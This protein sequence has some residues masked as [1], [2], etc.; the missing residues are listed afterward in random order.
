MNNATYLRK[1]KKALSA[2]EKS[3]IDNICNEI[4]S[5][6]VD[7]EANLHAS[8]GSPDVLTMLMSLHQS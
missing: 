1:L 3:E 2:L 6:A 5:Y 7:T 8:L 4:S